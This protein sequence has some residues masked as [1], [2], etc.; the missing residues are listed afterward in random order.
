M[1]DGLYRGTTVKLHIKWDPENHDHPMAWAWEGVLEGCE[2]SLIDFEDD[3][4]ET[5]PNSAVIKEE[6]G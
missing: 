5:Y 2:V 4:E 6:W 1:S 3:R